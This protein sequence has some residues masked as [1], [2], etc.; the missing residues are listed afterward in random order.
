VRDDGRGVDAEALR[1]KVVEGGVLTYGEAK[2]MPAELLL[3]AL[4]ASGFSTA[5][6]VTEATGR[7]VGLDVVRDAARRLGGDAA[8]AS[9]P[10]RGFEVRV[11]FPYEA[12]RFDA[13]L[14]V[15][16]LGSELEALAAAVRP[17]ASQVELVVDPVVARQALV[18]CDRQRL[19]LAVKEMVA[20][21]AAESGKSSMR[22]EL[23]DE[24]SLVVAAKGVKADDEVMGWLLD[25]GITPSEASTARGTSIEGVCLTMASAA[26]VLPASG[27]TVAVVGLPA[28]AA[29]IFRDVAADRFG[30]LPITV[31][32]TAAVSPDTI[33]VFAQDALNAAPPGTPTDATVVV[34]AHDAAAL[35]WDALFSWTDDPLVVEGAL[36][37]AAA[38]QALEAT[39]LRRR[40]DARRR[41]PA[42]RSLA[43]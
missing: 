14:S 15:F 16:N 2:H 12:S 25:G 4:F 27:L 34:I 13:R 37:A 9:E 20:R 36:D 24:T 33:L 17:Y 6:T 11:H 41:A 23:L 26:D 29:T 1:A 30:G 35:P 40:L 5:R 43:A 18:T 32:D 21:A 19:G 10:G 38:A 31:R 28:A 42:P 7:G 39:L 22:L 8:V 3:E